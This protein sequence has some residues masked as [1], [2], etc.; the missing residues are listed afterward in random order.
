VPTTRFLPPILPFEPPS[1]SGDP[2]PCGTPAAEC[3]EGPALGELRIETPRVKARTA[4]ARIAASFGPVMILTLLLIVWGTASWG[5]PASPAESVPMKVEVGL[6]IIDIAKLDLKENQFYADF[7]IWY[8]WSRNP[9]LDWSPEKVEFMNGTI[10]TATKLASE[11]LAS[12]KEYAS[13]RI[14]GTFRGRFKLHSYPFDTQTLPIILEDQESGIHRVVFVPDP[15]VPDSRKWVEA[16]VQ[17]PDWQIQGT[18]AFTDVHH[19]DTNFGDSTKINSERNSHYSRFTFQVKLGRFFIPH[20]IKFI[21]PLLVIAGMAYMVFFINAKEFEA[22]CGICVTSLL[23]AVALHMSQADALPAVG[24]LVLSDK[25]FILFYVTIFS[26]LVQTVVANNYAKTGK[27]DL[28][29]K[30]DWLFQI[31]YPLAILG[32]T[33]LVVLTTPP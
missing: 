6:Y 17:V 16:D 25:I 13:Q 27:V 28:A 7:Y 24:Y 5:Q 20:M 3:F 22:Q 1:A 15:D 11:T 23:S 32:G 31:I 12:G 19:Y 4:T 33:I 21:I 9:D 2:L 30:L 14:K 18:N 29:M 10:E 8:K 26:A